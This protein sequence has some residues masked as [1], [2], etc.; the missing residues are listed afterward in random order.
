MKNKT[1]YL[2]LG[3]PIILLVSLLIFSRYGRPNESK[4]KKINIPYGEMIEIPELVTKKE[5]KIQDISFLVTNDQILWGIA[6]SETEKHYFE[7]GSIDLNLENPVS[8]DKY[9]YKDQGARF[10]TDVE[11]SGLSNTILNIYLVERPIIEK[12]IT[13]ELEEVTLSY[14]Q[15]KHEGLKTNFELSDN[16]LLHLIKDA[17]YMTKEE[18]QILILSQIV[19]GEAKGI[20][21]IE[22]ADYF[23]NQS[24]KITSISVNEKNIYVTTTDKTIRIY[25]HTLDLEKKVDLSTYVSDEFTSFIKLKYIEQIDKNIVQISPTKF[26][27]LDNEGN[28]K[29]WEEK[30]ISEI[31]ENIVVFEMK[32]SFFYQEE[33]IKNT[34]YLLD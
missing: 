4:W 28:L 22:V 12:Y 13:S 32:R 25:N 27:W 9:D 3:L 23:E 29:E 34:R 2:S 17:D 30:N 7:Y 10:V 21:E 31:S 8:T 20:K 16:R 15:L 1:F 33:S 6:N 14:K 19:D 18:N 5:A 26:C 24:E 11:N